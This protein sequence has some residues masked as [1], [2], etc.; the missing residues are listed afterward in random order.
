MITSSAA[1]ALG[2]DNSVGSLSPEKH[3]DLLFFPADVDDPD[4]LL[5]NLLNSA[6][7]PAKVWIGGTPVTFSDL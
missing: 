7:A 5:A 6:P 1:R 3:A 4:A 2:L